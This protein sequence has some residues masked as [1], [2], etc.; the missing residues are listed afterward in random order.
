[1]RDLNDLFFFAEVVAHGGFAAAGRALRQPKS[2][3]SRRVAQ[4]EAR[5]GVRLIERSSRRFRVTD[6]GQTFYEHC[7]NV[8]AEVSQ[9]EAQVAATQGESHGEVRFSCPLGMMEVVSPMLCDFLAH[10]PRVN[11]RVMATNRRVDLI[12]ERIDVALRVRTVLD[13][14]AALTVRVLGRSRRVLVVG[15]A[16]ASRLEDMTEPSGLATHPTLSSSEQPGQEVWEL[17]GPDSQ[18]CAVRHEPRLACGDFAAL[19]DA[20]G[21]GLGVA[22]LP[23][24]VC[25]SGLRS[26]QLVHLLPDWHALDG[27]VHLV[28]TARRGLPPPVSAWIAWLAE[29]FR[30]PSLRL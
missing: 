9:A 17:E 14:D 2:K 5:L 22:L 23:E 13:T 8:M 28:F 10:H 6:V 7:Q 24:H 12:H 11:V 16:L 18:R 29:R 19:R 25:V 21:A 15:A 4:L 20:A 27:T 3:L 30:D 26:G 1:M